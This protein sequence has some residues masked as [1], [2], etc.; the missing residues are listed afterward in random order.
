[1]GVLPACILCIPGPEEGAESHQAGVMDVRSYRA[2]PS[3]LQGQQV[4]QTAKFSRSDFGVIFVF[5]MVFKEG[6]I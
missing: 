2:N 6:H 5:L 3:P 4:L 1:M